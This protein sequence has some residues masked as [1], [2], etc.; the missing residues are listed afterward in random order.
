LERH[1]HARDLCRRALL[2]RH[3]R[4]ACTRQQLSASEPAFRRDNIPK[5]TSYEIVTE[6]RLPAWDVL[7]PTIPR[8]FG[9]RWV[10]QLRSAIVLVPSYVARLERNIVINPAHPDSRSVNATPLP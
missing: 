6:D 5:S 8:E 9:A 7:E 2:D 10:N 4:K 3:A 1:D